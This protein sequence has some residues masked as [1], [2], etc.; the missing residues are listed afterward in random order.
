[1]EWML[2]ANWQITSLLVVGWLYRSTRENGGIF[3]VLESG[4]SALW[5]AI[6]I[7]PEIWDRE[8]GDIVYGTV[9]SPLV[10]LI[11]E[12]VLSIVSRC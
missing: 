11:Q 1:M 10:S 7:G 5:L 3:A 12:F 6:W 9:G 2:L 4:H 8:I